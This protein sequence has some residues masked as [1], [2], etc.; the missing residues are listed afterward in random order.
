VLGLRDNLALKPA[1]LACK[2]L[3]LVGEL[4]QDESRGAG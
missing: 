4:R 1:D 3:D 2:Q